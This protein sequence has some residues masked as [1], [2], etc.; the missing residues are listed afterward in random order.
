[1]ST[2][3]RA[4]PVSAAPERRPSGNAPRSSLVLRRCACGGAAG[5]SGTCEECA[6]KRLQRRP[7]AGPRPAVPVART[8]LVVGAEDDRYEQEAERAAERVMRMAGPALAGGAPRAV[9]RVS[10]AA[11]GETA[12][13]PIVHD[14]LASPGQPLEAGTRAFFEPRF[15]H[16]FSHVR[17]H[18]DARAGE[19]A[20]AVGA[21]A[22]TVGHHVVFAPDRFAP[23]SASGRW[24]VA[25]ELTHVLQQGFGGEA[26]SG[27]AAVHTGARGGR[28]SG[29]AAETTGPRP[30]RIPG[31]PGVLQRSEGDDRSRQSRPRNAPRG[32]R[33]IDQ[34]GLDREDVH[35]IKDGVGAGPRDWVGITPEGDVVTTDAD[36]NAENH[37]PASDYLRR[38]HTEIPSWLWPLVTVVG[39]VVVAGIIACF[40]TGVCEFA[41]VVG[42]LSY[43]TAMMILGL[44]RSAG[45]R[46]SGAAA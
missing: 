17:V 30:S 9:Q 27:A 22:Y 1:M 10:A 8:G 28:A 14:V 35:T 12:A 15:G 45:I 25:H 20:R 23:G 26:S 33:P 21:L 7:L 18:T 16:D 24:L 34:S 3:T 4:A 46:D 2:A 39:I 5:L 40:A 43:A 44:L 19:S 11:T 31:T 29:D 13:P 41:A 37:G 6:K 38:T 36:G 32:T 42:G